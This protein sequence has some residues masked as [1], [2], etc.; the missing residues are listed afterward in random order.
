M[1]G[2]STNVRHAEPVVVNVYDLS[3]SNE[4]LIHVGLGFYHSG[5]EIHGV[6]YTFSNDGVQRHGPRQAQ[7]PFRCAIKISTIKMSSMNVDRVVSDLSATRFRPGTYDLRTKNCNHFAEAL[8]LE[9]SRTSPPGWINRIACIG[10][11][12]DCLFPNSNNTQ[13]SAISR[14]RNVFGGHGYT[15][16]S[17]GS[18]VT[19]TN[20]ATT[21]TSTSSKSPSS[22]SSSSSI[23]DRRK[24]AAD[25]AMRRIQAK[26]KKTQQ[27]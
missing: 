4:Y 7:A 25:A 15:L 26:K 23:K 14:P 18:S 16:A 12:C 22:S 3:P 9:L 6:E 20:T 5:V 11:Y 24:L 2:S 19:T 10:S 13:A 17:S 8:C 21:T 27:S 1:R